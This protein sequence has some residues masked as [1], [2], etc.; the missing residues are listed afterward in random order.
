MNRAGTG[1]G[2]FG[3]P[4]LQRRLQGGQKGEK[5]ACRGPRSNKEEW[6]G[7]DP[8]A[9]AEGTHQSDNGMAAMGLF[10]SG[11]GYS[12]H[13]RAGDRGSGDGGGAAL[14]GTNGLP[15]GAAIWPDTGQLPNL[16][17]PMLKV[18]TP[19]RMNLQTIHQTH[20]TPPLKN[21]N[22]SQDFQQPTPK[23]NTIDH[24]V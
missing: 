12:A 17:I 7:P 15:L 13:L 16:S 21:Q 23:K 5:L 19:P 24:L 11:P 18:D 6:G 22:T 10:S 2:R 1:G 8:P 20:K 9:G 14:G 3:A 4:P